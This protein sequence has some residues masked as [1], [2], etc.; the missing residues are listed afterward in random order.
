MST[1]ARLAAEFFGSIVLLA[2]V[3]G[4][5][6][7]GE[8]L[9]AGN[10]AVALLANAIATGCGLYVLIATLGPVSG[11]H[12]NPLVTLMFAVQR[13]IGAPL[14]LA[15]VVVQ[16]AGAWLGVLLAHAMFDLELLQQAT[17]L[18][19]GPGQLTGELVATAGLLLVVALATR[20][21]S[22]STPAL[23]AAWITS[24][25]WFT[26]STSFANPAVTLARGFTYT[27]AGIAP[28]SWPWFL[29][30]QL[31]GAAIAIALCA[32]WRAA[33]PGA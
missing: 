30:G 2:I 16:V 17:K 13:A 32:R 24:A 4:S 27:F 8:R 5:G 22:S 6:V 9:A 12:F 33:D 18:R 31:A 23:V 21:R 14:A 11:A 10:A 3:V 19:D 20:A 28:A 1:S 15:Y 26:S 25:Y 7:M 29:A